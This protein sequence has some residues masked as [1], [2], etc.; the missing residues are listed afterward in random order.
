MR[1]SLLMDLSYSGI[2]NDIAPFL[3]NIRGKSLYADY[4]T[5]RNASETYKYNRLMESD[6]PQFAQQVSTAIA[7]LKAK[8][9]SGLK[10][11]ASNVMAKLERSRLQIEAKERGSEGLP[12]LTIK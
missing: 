10:T 4:V 5:I 1:L 6:R 7:R 12:A 2:S 8:K 9:P 3:E 11:E